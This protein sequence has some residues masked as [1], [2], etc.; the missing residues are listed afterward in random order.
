MK[1]WYLKDNNIFTLSPTLPP[2][3]PGM[4]QSKI[5]INM[6][7][8]NTIII[9]EASELKNVTKMEKAQKIGGISAENQKVQN[10]KFGLFDKKGGGGFRIFIFFP[11]LNI[12]F[13]FFS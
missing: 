1:T 13:K 9:R 2:D 10:S 4:T 12:D 7:G 6:K 3:Y 5:L 11:N 8:E